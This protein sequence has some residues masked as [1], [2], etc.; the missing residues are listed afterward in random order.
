MFYMFYEAFSFNQDLCAWYNMLQSTTTVT[1]M[2]RFSSCANPET[3][4]FT[5]KSSLCQTCKGKQSLCIFFIQS[6]I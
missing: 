2:F 3:P 6:C 4:D 5:T 1:D